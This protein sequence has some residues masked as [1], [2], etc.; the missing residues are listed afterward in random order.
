MITCPCL[1]AF[2]YLSVPGG[3][4]GP[5]VDVLQLI[6]GGNLENPDFRTMVFGE[7]KTILPEIDS[8]YA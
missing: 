6:F 7:N 5:V 2:H 4:I 8:F 1:T 3:P